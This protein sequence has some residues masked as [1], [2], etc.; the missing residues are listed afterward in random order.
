[1][2]LKVCIVYEDTNRTKK[3][4]KHI[5]EVVDDVSF[6]SL[7]QIDECNLDESD[8]CIV[9]MPS[10][11]IQY[12][13]PPQ[14]ILS[15]FSGSAFYRGN[16]GLQDISL[17]LCKAHTCHTTVLNGANIIQLE[18]SKPLQIATLTS[19]CFLN[20]LTKDCKDTVRLPCTVLMKQLTVQCMRRAFAAIKSGKCMTD[21]SSHM[22][23]VVIK[24]AFGGGSK[25][26]TI[27]YAICADSNQE[28][29]A[30]LDTL[31][32]LKTNGNDS[33]SRPW[34]MQRL[35]GNVDL[36]IRVEVIGWKVCYA[37]VIRKT[38]KEDTQ[39]GPW[40]EAENLCMCEVND[41]VQLTLCP[42]PA[43]LA[44]A[45]L[46]DIGDKSLRL[47]LATSVF[48]YSQTL[49]QDVNAAVLAMEFLVDTSGH[50]YIIDLNFNSNYNFA[51]EESLQKSNP[52]F[53]SS[54]ERYLEMF[55]Y[56]S[57]K[58]AG[59]Q[60]LKTFKD[61]MLTAPISKKVPSSTTA[62]EDMADV[63]IDDTKVSVEALLNA[64]GNEKDW[65]KLSR[66]WD[67]SKAHHVLTYKNG[68]A[69]MEIHRSCVT[70]LVTYVELKKD[71]SV[72]KYWLTE[73][74]KGA[75]YWLT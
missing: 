36:Q 73:K 75:K 22:T 10:S 52:R 13:D 60:Q 55:I 42:T 3:L 68:S 12:A 8:N 38:T 20:K 1:M 26:V 57:L 25:G 34:L 66:S 63:Y 53:V 30:K 23:G 62:F 44:D 56:S 19:S 21:G 2:A 46:T 50:A 16:A 18:D 32:K 6:D 65:E 40:K 43:M 41:D 61:A 5:H 45:L 54:A 69:V 64:I 27:I 74:I 47:Q 33:S 70:N 37:V 67:S 28:L 49:S 9:A 14:T 48:E 72:A 4:M 71:P 35:V 17:L 39:H 15:R 51:A 24:P 58:N 11:E 59:S 7:I 29:P 31:V